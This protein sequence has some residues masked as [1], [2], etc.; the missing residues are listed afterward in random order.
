MHPKTQFPRGKC[1]KKGQILADSAAMVGGEL[2]LGKNVLVSYMPWEGY[3]SEDTVLISEHLVY[4]DIY[5]SLNIRKY[6]IQT[7]VTSQGPEKVT[8]EIPHLEAHLLRNLDKNGIVMLGSWVETGDILVGKLTPQVVKEPSMPQKIDCYKLYLVFRY[9]LQGS[10]H[11]TTTDILLSLEGLGIMYFLSYEEIPVKIL[12]RQVCRLWTKDVDLVKVLW[13]NHKVEE[14]TWEVEEDIKSKYLHLLS[15]PGI[16]AKDSTCKYGRYNDT[17]TKCPRLLNG[18]WIDWFL[19]NGFNWAIMARCVVKPWKVEVPR[20]PKLETH[21]CQ[22]EPTQGR[23]LEVGLGWVMGV[24][25]GP[26]QTWD[27]HYYKAPGLRGS[28]CSIQSCTYIP[29][30]HPITSLS[31]VSY[32]K[33]SALAKI[34]G[35]QIYYFMEKCHDIE[36]A[37]GTPSSTFVYHDN[38]YE[39]EEI[40]G[41]MDKM[42]S[43]LELLVEHMLGEK[44]E[45]MSMIS[46]IEFEQCENA[47]E[48]VRGNE[49]FLELGE[50][51]LYGQRRDR[52]RSQDIPK[53]HSSRLSQGKLRSKWSGPFVISN[54][55]PNGAFELEDNEG[56]KFLV[57]GQRVK[58]Y[59]E[60]IPMVAKMECINFKD[61]MWSLNKSSVLTKIGE[62]SARKLAAI[63]EIKNIAKIEEFR[64]SC[65][66]RGQQT[67]IVSM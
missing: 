62:K 56:R 19:D 5:T 28:L 52:I 43:C 25:S 13:W 16:R 37:M 35:S 39:E 9:G 27:S 53:E 10:Y 6:E 47:K 8:N 49:P 36:V 44:I 58:H 11:D 15:A 61:A 33:G 14:A 48:E 66:D 50:V 34:F 51:T 21:I 57:K 17:T 59:N 22:Y 1:I 23:Q 60:I 46:A 7:H 26:G 2:A 38:K 63:K 12:D 24:V 54:V 30:V 41:K 45:S 40:N 65:H 3:N 20:V 67:V 29:R 64:L 32:G 42:M 31:I 4:K 55:Y 18:K